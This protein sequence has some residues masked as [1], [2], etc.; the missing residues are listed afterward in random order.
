MILDEQQICVTRF[1]KKKEKKKASDAGNT[2]FYFVAQFID[3]A[4]YD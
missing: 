3:V 2:K 1:S 4:N